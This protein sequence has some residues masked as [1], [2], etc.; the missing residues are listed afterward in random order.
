MDAVK[1]IKEYNRMCNAHDEIKK[2]NLVEKNPEVYVLVVEKWSADHPQK[3]RLKDFLEKYP[4]ARMTSEGLPWSCCKSLGYV[5]ADK[6]CGHMCYE[7]W[8][9]AV[10]DE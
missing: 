9:T 7:C 10:E 6:D 1:F 5:D 3:T 2:W 4:M 8:N